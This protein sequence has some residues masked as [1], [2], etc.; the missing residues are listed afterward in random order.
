M[1]Q[2]IKFDPKKLAKPNNPKQY[3]CGGLDKYFKHVNILILEYANIL[4]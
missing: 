3:P 1:N 4:K 2:S